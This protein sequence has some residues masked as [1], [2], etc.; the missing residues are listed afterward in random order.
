MPPEGAQGMMEYPAPVAT[1]EEVL[2]NPELF[3][4]TLR[5]FHSL[6]GT[7]FMIP[8]IG[9]KELDLHLLY[10]EVTKRGGLEK[11]VGE[12]KW[13]EVIT[14]FNFPPTTTSA[15]FV[16]RKYYISLLHHYEKVYY[17][18]LRG[19]LIPPAVT[20]PAKSPTCKPAIADLSMSTPDGLQTRGGDEQAQLPKKRKRLQIGGEVNCPVVGVIDTKFD[21]GY[22]VTVKIGEN[23]LRGVLFHPADSASP[24]AS[25]RAQ[26]P[27][28]GGSPTRIHRRRKRGRRR[29]DPAHP[30]PNRSAYNFFFA[31]KHSML[32]V[33]YPQREREFSKMIGESWNKLTEEERLT[34]LD[35]GVKDKE[36]YKRE[37]QE[38]RE[39]LK[40][41]QAVPPLPPPPAAGIQQSAV[42]PGEV[43]KAASSSLQ[44]DTKSESTTS[45]I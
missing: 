14:A 21:H 1:H 45:D 13:K 16:L 4:D 41:V 7:R 8:V 23:L 32:K 22:L 18:R 38:Y 19:P 24:S 10:L 35:C 5:R 20:V 11:V 34:Y 28:S 37:M 31:E 25:E 42:G 36:R 12:R 15:S 27:A 29:W 9:G 26:L 17:F 39:R 3:M 43:R 40:L 33:L 6:M 44:M 30:K 2:G